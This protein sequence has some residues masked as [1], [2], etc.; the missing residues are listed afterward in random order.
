MKIHVGRIGE[1]TDA[2]PY[3]PDTDAAQWSVVSEDEEGFEIEIP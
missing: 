3:R 1:G 2:D